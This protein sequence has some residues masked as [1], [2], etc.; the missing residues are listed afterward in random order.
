MICW[1]H[2]Y[3]SGCVEEEVRLVLGSNDHEGLVEICQSNSWRSICSSSWDI[4]DA[5]VVCRQLGFPVA[6][7]P[8]IESD[9]DSAHVYN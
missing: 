4:N 7:E 2:I 5:R 6:G 9:I 1:G 8:L 3:I